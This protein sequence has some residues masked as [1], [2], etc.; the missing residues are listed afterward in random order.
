MAAQ[1]RTNRVSYQIPKKL[2][3]EVFRAYDI[4]GLVDSEHITPD[5]AY[6]VGLAVGTQARNLGQNAIIVGR[7]GRLS[8]P[9]LHPA[10]CAGLLAA[11]VNIAD[12][13]IVPTPLVYYATF[14]YGIP[15]GVMITASHNPGNHNGFKIILDGKTL[16]SNDILAIYNQILEQRFV[17]GHGQSTVLGCV[18]DDY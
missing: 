15:S 3:K 10:L 1:G 17:S 5:L 13:G 8:G 4:R 6:A 7:D 18:I 2:P 12:I 16:T 11:G 14:R 9:A